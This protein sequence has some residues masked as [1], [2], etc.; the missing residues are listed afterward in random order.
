MQA[1][2]DLVK[3]TYTV[4]QVSK[5]LD[6]QEVTLRS[7]E[8]EL[9]LK[10]S[11]DTNKYRL[12]TMS[13]IE[14][15][16]QIRDWRAKCLTLGSI[17]AFLGESGTIEKQ[18]IE[19]LVQSDVHALSVKE[20]QEVFR[21]TIVEIIQERE[22]ELEAKFEAR[23]SSEL[24]KATSKFKEEIQAEN[25]KL[26]LYLEK[27]REEQRQKKPSFWSFLKRN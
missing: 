12:Y 14:L 5:M 1:E 11:R 19:G 2:E 18:R 26:L 3:T 22:Q 8:R 25:A 9:N 7:W 4:K 24:E 21:N 13:D 16:T 20:M 6:V 10:I 23:L 15:L 27:D 17:K